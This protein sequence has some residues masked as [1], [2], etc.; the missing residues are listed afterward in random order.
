MLNVDNVQMRFFNMYLGYVAVDVSK[1]ICIHAC[2]SI[3]PINAELRSLSK[4][5][6]CVFLSS[7]FII[8]LQLNGLE[9]EQC[10]WLRA[11]T[12]I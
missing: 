8:E 3:Y 1:F 12:R 9:R 4:N 5:S 2:D 10:W 11:S 6:V 7:P